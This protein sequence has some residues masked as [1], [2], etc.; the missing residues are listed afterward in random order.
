ML[1]HSSCTSMAL[2][3]YGIFMGFEAIVRRMNHST[4]R[5][6]SCTSIQWLIINSIKFTMAA[7]HK[8]RIISNSD[9][10]SWYTVGCTHC[11]YNMACLAGTRARY[12]YIHSI[13]HVWSVTSFKPFA[14]QADQKCH[15]RQIFNQ[16]LDVLIWLII[17]WLYFTQCTDRGRALFM[18]CCGGTEARLASN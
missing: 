13:L 1:S 18:P 5:Q 8:G 4:I 17:Y 14:P 3:N 12:I 16:L 10:A 2:F 7:V 9:S 11:V 15:K 6:C